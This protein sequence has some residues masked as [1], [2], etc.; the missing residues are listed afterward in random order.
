MGGMMALEFSGIAGI[1]RHAILVGRQ[2]ISRLEGLHGKT[3]AI[4]ISDATDDRKRVL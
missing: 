2:N 3:D 4:T 1:N